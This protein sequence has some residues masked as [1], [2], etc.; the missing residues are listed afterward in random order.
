MA[1]AYLGRSL[2]S[3][4]EHS[5]SQAAR[6]V[7]RLLPAAQGLHT[8]GLYLVRAQRQAC[9]VLPPYVVGKLMSMFDAEDNLFSRHPVLCLL[10]MSSPPCLLSCASTIAPSASMHSYIVS[11]MSSLSSG[12]SKDCVLS[13][14]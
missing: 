9:F 4:F 2:S 6:V 5:A 1:E 10:H 8:F 3:A 11:V 7:H 13:N 14:V 12:C